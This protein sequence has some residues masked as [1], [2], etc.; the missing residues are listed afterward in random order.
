MSWRPEYFYLFSILTA[1]GPKQY[2]DVGTKS[3]M[4]LP[5]D[6]SLVK[7]KE[8]KKH[9]LRYAKD[10]DVFFKEFSDV[11]GKLFELGVPFKQEE[12]YTFTATID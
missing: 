1:A 11:V 2:E 6:M 9:V 4:M 10:Q 5:A 12:K 8:F 3:L 7:D